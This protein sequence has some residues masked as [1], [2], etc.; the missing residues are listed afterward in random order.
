MRG[1]GPH[2]HKLK[3]S[4]IQEELL[5]GC[6]N[7]PE[8]WLESVLASLSVN[9]SKNEQT[10]ADNLCASRGD[11]FSSVHTKIILHHVIVLIAG[12]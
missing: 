3:C 5:E 9:E 12:G 4:N 2:Y 7:Q 10:L 1:S 6:L 11:I 8:P